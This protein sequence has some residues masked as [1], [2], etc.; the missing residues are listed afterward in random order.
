[1]VNLLV[2]KIDPNSDK[3]TCGKQAHHEDRKEREGF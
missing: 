2:S 1:M 3:P